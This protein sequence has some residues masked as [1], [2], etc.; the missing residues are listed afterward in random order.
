MIKENK[1]FIKKLK[2][3]IFLGESK[4][5]KDLEKI[6]K[7]LKLETMIVS[8]SHQAKSIDNNI[9]VKVFDHLDDTFKKLI[10]RNF[11]IE[12]TLFISLGAR[13]IFKKETINKFFHNN[14]VNFHNT[15]LPLDAGGG[16][17][18]WN[19]L[20]E[21]RINNQLVHLIDGGIDTGPIIENEINLFPASC[22]IPIDFKK[23]SS[24][25]FL[26]FYKKFITKILEGRQIE[27]KPQINYFGRY[28]PRLNTA[29]NGFIDW[30]L[31]PYDLINFI[32]AFDEPYS[33]ALTYLNNGNFGKL[34]IKK[35]QLHGG[36]SSNHP[37]MT[38]IVNRHDGDWIVVST[39]GRHM[40]II[41][42]VLD[43]NK[44]NIIEKI[45]VG[46]RFYTDIKDIESGKNK[47]VTYN[48]KGLKK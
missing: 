41:E 37:F 38:G 46:D 11:D 31:N 5:L 45:K 1:F 16:G 2:S 10:S 15:R 6:N 32:N 34:S 12:N 19:I 43:K 42:E 20:R 14:L 40:L 9:K 25:K 4:S 48:S 36:D 23:F 29:L 33:G 21:D 13:Y 8:S 47:R 30:N 24:E 28:N 26:I 18:S 22:K 35:A 39:T 44:K 7:S 17:F 3:I 27:L